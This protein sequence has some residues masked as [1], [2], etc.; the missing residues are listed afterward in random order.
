MGIATDPDHPPVGEGRTR[1]TEWSREGDILI[2]R[3]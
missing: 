3:R 2:L 1:Y